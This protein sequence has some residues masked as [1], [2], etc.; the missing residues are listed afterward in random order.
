MMHPNPNATWKEGLTL[1]KIIQCAA[2]RSSEKEEGIRFSPGARGGISRIESKIHA[3][4]TA[5]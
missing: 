3:I 2:G 4:R 1:F 5:H